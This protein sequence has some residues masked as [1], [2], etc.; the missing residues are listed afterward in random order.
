MQAMRTISIILIIIGLVFGLFGLKSLYRDNI[1]AKASTVAKAS[2]TSAEI[3]PM[4]GKAVG[5]I[6]LILS[7]LRDG[8]AD[9]TEY[10][11]TEEFTNKNPLPTEAELKA[12]TYYV[13]YVP[14]EKRSK[15]TPNWLMVNS[16][17]EFNG[18]YGRSQFGQMFVFILLGFMVRMFGLKR[19]I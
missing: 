10:K 16:T 18:W 3:K 2:V 6:R 11:F 4:S 19:S 12:K 17:G 13:R 7:Y 5:S 1:Y 9:S 14:L 15:N 8:V